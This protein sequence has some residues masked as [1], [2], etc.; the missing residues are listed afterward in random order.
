VTTKSVERTAETIGSD[1]AQR[2]QQEFHRAMQLNLPILVGEPIPILYVQMDGTGVPVV[3]NETLR[4]ARQGQGPTR[5]Y[6]GGQ[7]GLRV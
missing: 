6:A 4:S 7:A 1:I 2:E 3:K 5:S